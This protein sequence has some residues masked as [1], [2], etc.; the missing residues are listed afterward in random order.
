MLFVLV[1]EFFICWTPLH[2]V[3]SQVD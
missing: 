2:F 1:A 3:V